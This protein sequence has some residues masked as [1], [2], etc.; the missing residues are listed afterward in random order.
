M[1]ISETV[2]TDLHKRVEGMDLDTCTKM[3]D[4]MPENM[5]DIDR[6]IKNM[7]QDRIVALGK[8]GGKRAVFRVG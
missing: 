8:G 2:Y 4:N 1:R 5:G 7:I 6:V 3:I